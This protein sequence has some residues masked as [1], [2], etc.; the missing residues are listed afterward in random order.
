MR[1]TPA[2]AG[3][4]IVSARCLCCALLW[5]FLPLPLVTLQFRVSGFWV[6]GSWTPGSLCFLFLR[7]K[8]F[9]YFEC[10]CSSSKC[11][12]DSC[13]GLLEGLAACGAMLQPRLRPQRLANCP[14]DT[15]TS[16]LQHRA[17]LRADRLAS[18]SSPW[19]SEAHLILAIFT[20]DSPIGF[21]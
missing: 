9:V 1:S 6:L 10:P 14:S 3:Y 4:R 17:C 15:L 11:L 19:H 12:T 21:Q 5:C 20:R 8:P 2:G 16:G 7:S 18:G 13:H